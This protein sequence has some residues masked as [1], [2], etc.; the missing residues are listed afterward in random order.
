MWDF[1]KKNICLTDD[2]T[3]IKMVANLEMIKLIGDVDG[4][5]NSAFV[6]TEW[7]SMSPFTVLL[8]F[9]NT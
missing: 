1:R 6:F 8:A 9:I 7:K 3:E 5:S 2:R 4:G